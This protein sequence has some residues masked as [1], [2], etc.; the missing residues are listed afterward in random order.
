MGVDVGDRD[1]LTFNGLEQSVRDDVKIVKDCP[2]INHELPV[3]GYI[4][5]AR[6]DLGPRH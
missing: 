6:A 4:Y 3:Y 5:D 2:M 1:F